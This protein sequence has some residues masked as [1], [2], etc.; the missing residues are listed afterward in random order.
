MVTPRPVHPIGWLAQFAG[1]LSLALAC[2]ASPAAAP[3]PDTATAKYEARFME[4]MIDHHMMAVHMSEMCLM[5]AFHPELQ[6]LCLQ[7]KTAQQQ[8]IMAMEQWL[9][10]WYG[11]APGAHEMNPGQHHR[12]QKLAELSGAEF[13]IEFMQQMIRHHHMAVVKSSQCVG[14]AYHAEL[15]DLCANIVRTQLAEIEQMQAWLCSWYGLCRPRG[16]S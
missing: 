11:V 15:Q 1:M 2:G 7:M 5:K 9:V 8:E 16:G 10:T 14:R 12:M 4:E 13:E 6:A 3:A